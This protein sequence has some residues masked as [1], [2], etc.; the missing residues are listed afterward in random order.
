[1]RPIPVEFVRPAAGTTEVA[2]VCPGCGARLSVKV[3]N[4]RGLRCRKY[5]LPATLFLIA[6]GALTTACMLPS[7]SPLALM[8]IIVM[9]VSGIG[10]LLLLMEFAGDRGLAI[11]HGNV[12]IKATFGKPALLHAFLEPE[13]FNFEAIVRELTQLVG[14]DGGFAQRDRIRVLG[15]KLNDAGGIEEMQRAYARVREAGAYFSQDIWD[16]VGVWRK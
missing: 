1:M 8:A 5:G 4:A 9:A 11:S 16:G 2:I 15:A 3:P 6:A 14:G 13:P 10:L 12:E 7:D